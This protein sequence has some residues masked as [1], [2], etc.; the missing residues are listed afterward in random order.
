MVLAGGEIS[1]KSMLGVLPAAGLTW[2]LRGAG[3][4][5]A[6]LFAHWLHQRVAAPDDV[7]S[8][9]ALHIPHPH[10]NAAGFRA[11]GNRERG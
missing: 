3:L 9:V 6:G 2:G 8:L 4:Q 11:L 7:L 5:V 1:G 10:A